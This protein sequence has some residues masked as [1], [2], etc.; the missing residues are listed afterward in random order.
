M[1]IGNRELSMSL[2]WYRMNRIK[3]ISLIAG[4]FVLSSLSMA[5][6][7]SFEGEARGNS[8]LYNVYKGLDDLGVKDAWDMG[9]TGN[10]VIVAIIDTGIDFA[11][12]DLMGTQARVS[13][14]SSPYYGWPIVIDL[15][16]L[17]SYQ[18]GIPAYN[19]WYANTTSVDVGNC[20]V[21]GTSKSGIYHIGDHPDL[22]LAS[23]YGRP[24]KVLVVDEKAAGVYDTVYVDL[25]DNLDFRDDKPCRKGDEIS[26]W[27]R[28]SDG[29]ADE[30]GG[31]IYFIAD[32]QTP[33]P[34]SKMCYGEKAKIAGNGELVAFEYDS[35][36]HGT[37]CASIVAAQGKNILGI[38]PDAR[39]M[40][41]R[42]GEENELLCLLTALGYDGVPNTGDEGDIISR[43]GGLMCQLNKGG[44][45]SSAFLEYLSTNISPKTTIVYANGNDGSGY[46]TCNPPLGEHTI[47]VGATYD[48]WW[49][50]SSKK[51]DVT[52]FSSRGPN[53][54]GNVKPNLLAPGYRTPDSLPLWITHSGKAAWDGW[55]A[56]TSAATPHAA[57][58]IALIYQA[59]K[60]RYERFPTSTE[61]RDI[62]MS[63]ATDIDEEIFAQGSGMINATKAV[64][65][66][67]GMD[68]VLIEPALLI[69]PPIRAGSILEF[70]FTMT[71]YSGRQVRLIPQQLIKDKRRDLTLTPEDESFFIIPGDML[72]C[73]LLKV[74]SYYPRDVRNTKLE[75][76]EGYDIDLYNWR[77]SN[78]D[79]EL[80]KDELESVAL[81]IG[82][83]GYGFT[84][85]A[86]MHD[87]A[88]RVDDGLAVGLKR[89]GETKGNETKV[90]IETFNWRPWDIEIKAD[91]NRA[92]VS[93]AV[94]NATGTFQGKILLEG[95]GERQ[96]IPIS[97]STYRYDEVSLNNTNEIYENAR[98]YG[99]FEGDGKGSWDSRFYPLYHRGH[100]I[101][102]ID[103]TWEDPNTDIDIYLYGEDG[104][105]ASKLWKYP[106]KPPV[107]LPEL[108]ILRENGHSLRLSG[109]TFIVSGDWVRGGPPYNE[110][111]TS[112]G[113]NREVITGELTEGLNLIVLRQVV[114]GGSRYGENITIKVNITPIELIDLRAKAGET[115]TIM[116]IGVEDIRGFSK[117]RDLRVGESPETFQAEE[118][119]LLLICSNSTSYR[120]QLFYDSNKNGLMDLDT[121]EII[122]GEDRTDKINTSF[123]DMIP[124]YKNGTYF[125]MSMDL[126]ENLEFYHMKNRYNVSHSVP[127]KIRAPEKAGI[128][129]GIAEDE[130]C[131]ISI[132]ARLIVEAGEPA[133]LQLSAPNRTSN[134]MP[135]IAELE[136]EDK[137]QNPVE[138]NISATVE[139]NN[140][141]KTVELIKG[142]ASIRLTAPKNEGRY[143]IKAQ[144]RYGVTHRDIQI[145]PMTINET[146]SATNEIINIGV[147]DSMM[148]EEAF[149][150]FE[151]E[152][153]ASL[154]IAGNALGKVKSIS[155]LTKNGNI[156]LIWQSCMG[157][158]YYRVYRLN[159]SLA[160]TY[161][162][163]A[164]VK[165]PEY[166]LKG[167][168]WNSYTFRIS[169]VD[170]AGNESE[171]SDPVGIVVTP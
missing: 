104:I 103:A 133:Y 119:D 76:S 44:D 95:S 134:G 117:C 8:A 74:S 121:D 129:L 138:E 28:D 34:F 29:L 101:A 25:N 123:R 108:K 26:F 24:V 4:L 86:R 9:F 130:G 91:R 41:V 100:H 66:A 36:S 126:E 160:C 13:N 90:V 11:T 59:Y 110:F 93:I 61:A 78:G 88:G 96:C 171:L 2:S 51:G 46:G 135:F 60:E 49:N 27:D 115:V 92:N 68:G 150:V 148:A 125:L 159:S 50:G 45:V 65:I 142:K 10:G 153:I 47:N 72:S 56:G 69:T 114:P 32:G 156:N 79:G 170:S 67:C 84:S 144:S 141:I 97:F 75:K 120:P 81:D 105:N 64:E 140:D 111:S 40:S 70:N 147:N 139:F 87:P 7:C 12:P 161:E 137:F 127:T 106:T 63:S 43:S 98:I 53:A 83:W 6:S 16:S 124:I 116:P 21:T 166:S 145:A 163:L 57:G 143:D 109:I 33:L 131:F 17:A 5:D 38:A 80:Q 132:P 169:A 151:S 99:R 30:S 136:L 35:E 167:E 39:I 94:P 89:R 1:T 58:V 102:R 82:D 20:H 71:S 165:N 164:E 31:M 155:I 48:L 19:S 118:G 37:M 77:D 152:E 112:T 18:Q 23:Y 85:E 157:A 149:G 14:A 54:L 42:L 113:G 62:L 158:K 107:E 73:D 22:H 146:M 168:L 162:K 3:L 55:G 128:Y 15:N 122:F 52:R 154:A